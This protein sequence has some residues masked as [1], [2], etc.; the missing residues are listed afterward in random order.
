MEMF[1][2]VFIVSLISYFVGYG[3]GVSTEITFKKGG[4]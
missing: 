4:E 3:I 2:L 1:I